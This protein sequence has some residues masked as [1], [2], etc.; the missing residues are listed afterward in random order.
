MEF[1]INFGP[2]KLKRFNYSRLFDTDISYLL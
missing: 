1:I 2:I